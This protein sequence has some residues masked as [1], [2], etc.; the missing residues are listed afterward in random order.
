MLDTRRRMFGDVRPID[1]VMLII[2]LSVLVLIALGSLDQMAQAKA[3]GAQ[4]TS[5]LG[6]SRCATSYS[7]EK[8]PAT[9][10]AQPSEEMAQALRHKLNRAVSRD[11]VSLYVAE[12]HRSFLND[13]RTF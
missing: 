4:S 7:S 5:R 12:Q 6:P 9:W 10:G 13:C 1:W 8:S 3:G 11:V 2:K